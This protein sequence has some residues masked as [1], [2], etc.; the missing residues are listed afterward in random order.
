LKIA[1]EDAFSIQGK[2]SIGLYTT[3]LLSGF[4]RWAPS[5]EALLVP[6]RFLSSFPHKPVRKI[7]Y[8]AWLNTFL[9]SFLRKNGIDLIHFTNFLIPSVR[10]SEAK[11]AVTI[12]DL[13]PWKHPEVLP[14]LYLSFSRW[15]TLKSVRGADLILTSSETIRREVLE[16]FQVDERIVRTGSN[17]VGPE[18]GPLPEEVCHSRLSSFKRRV[19][20]RP[21]FLLFVGV[22]EARKNVLTL[23]KA[24]SRVRE[25]TDL[26]LVLV[27]RAGYQYVK[28]Q[29]YVKAYRMEDRVVFAGYVSP[30]ELIALY[31]TATLFVFP[32][33]YEGF[34]I[35]LI[36]AMAC[37]VPI[38]ASRIPSTEEVADDAVFYYGN[39][40][41]EKGLAAS[42]L[43]VLGDE[44][45]RLDLV[46]KGR[47]RAKRF[48]WDEVAKRHLASYKETLTSQKRTRANRP[49]RL[50]MDLER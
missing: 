29:E 27:G 14:P 21:P 16:L 34:G 40:L 45:L 31:N 18:F 41:D 13:V 37:G 1:L 10:R 20:F 12:H 48:T 28:L 9:Q 5:D 35:P 6:K 43:R 25:E 46:A 42:I 7:L 24:F 3:Q 47:E 33:L 49:S 15:A 8:I 38:V 22:L 2:A 11:Y 36:E 30:E 19:P 26:Q 44:Q 23:L 32:S 50:R 4:Q 17:G 39:P